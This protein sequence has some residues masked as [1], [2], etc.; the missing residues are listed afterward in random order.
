[1]KNRRFTLIE[2]LVVVAIIG[3][4]ASLLMPSLSTARLKARKTVCMSQSSQLSKFMVLSASDDDSRIFNY[5]NINNGNWIWDIT[6][7]ATTDWE[8]PREALYCPLR[9]DLNIDIMY[10]INPSYRVSAYA[11]T[12]VRQDGRV[13]G[14]DPANPNLP[15]GGIP[16]ISLLSH[17]EEPSETVMNADGTFGPPNYSKNGMISHLSNHYGYGVKLDMNATYA[18]GHSRLLRKGNFQNQ[19]DGFWW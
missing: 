16:F 10:N 15:S 3:I 12:H 18:D 5:P 8:I 6:V 2:L 19:Y 4:L 11:M 17:V 9:Q 13:T 7:Q 1:M 14:N